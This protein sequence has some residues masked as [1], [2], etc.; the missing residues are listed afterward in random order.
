MHSPFY[1]LFTHHFF[2]YIN[3]TGVNLGF[4]ESL[5]T[6]RVLPCGRCHLLAF[7]ITEW[8]CKNKGENPSILQL[9]HSPNF[10]LNSRFY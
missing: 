3:V 5:T 6:D 1:S 7:I 2:N 10:Q 8:Q 9:V 4:L